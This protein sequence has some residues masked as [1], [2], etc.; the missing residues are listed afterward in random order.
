[1]PATSSEMPMVSCGP[2]SYMLLCLQCGRF[3]ASPVQPTSLTILNPSFPQ[4]AT[5]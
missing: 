2:W 1:M 4:V 5:Y 3:V